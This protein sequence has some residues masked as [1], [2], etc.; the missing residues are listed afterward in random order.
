MEFRDWITKKYIEWRGETRNSV[1]QF[2]LY[3]GISQSTVSAW[4]NGTR[5]I[6]T[7]KKIISKLFEV[8]GDE[9]FSILGYDDPDSEKID[10]SSLPEDLQERFRTAMSE[11]DEAIKSRAGLVDS[12]DTSR[13]VRETFSKYGFTITKKE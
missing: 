7:S 11:I 8:Y 10:I 5:G 3:L 1:Q 9:I 2:S 12:E 6:P 13:L 4:I